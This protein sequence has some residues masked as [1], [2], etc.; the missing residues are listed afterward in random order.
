MFGL[1]GRRVPRM[2]RRSTESIKN[3]T[4]DQL[5][6]DIEGIVNGRLTPAE[7]AYRNTST[8]DQKPQGLYF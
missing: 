8:K 7:I 5:P 4:R 2:M 3:G 6:L 1:G